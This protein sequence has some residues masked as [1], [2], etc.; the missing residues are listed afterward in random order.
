MKEEKRSL[1]KELERVE[2]VCDELDEEN[3]NY[4]EEI[5]QLRRNSGTDKQPYSISVL[6]TY[7]RISVYIEISYS[8]KYC[9]ISGCPSDPTLNR[10][11]Q[12]LKVHEAVYVKGSWNTPGKPGNIMEF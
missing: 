5:R 11:N 7:N 12:K 10:E 3:Q 9:L 6:M 8:C 1:K 2:N 4:Q